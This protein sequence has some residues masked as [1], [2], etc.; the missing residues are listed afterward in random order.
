MD[1]ELDQDQSMLAKT[2]ADFARNESPVERFRKLRDDDVGYE[3]SVW[4]K[5]G[6]LGWLGVPFPDSVG[7]FGGTFTESAIVLENLATTL[8]PEPYLASVVLG[9][10]TLARA[11][12]AAQHEAYLT[13]MIEGETTL[14]L[15]YSEPH[16]RYDVEGVETKA[17]PDGGSY[18]LSGQKVWVQ[19]GHHADHL[20][21]SAQTPGGLSLFVVPRS[22]PGVTARVAKTIDGKNAAFVRFEGVRVAEDARLG[23]EGSAVAVLDRTMDY[24]AAGAVAESIGIAAEMLRLTIDYL[25]TREQ[26]GVKI[27]S[28]QALQHR[29]VDMYAETELLRSISMAAMVRADDD[30]RSARRAE[31]SAAKQQLATGGVWVAQ[32]ALQLHGGIGVTDEHD[33]GLYFKRMYALNALFGDS[34]HHVARFASDPSFVQ[35]QA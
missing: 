25:G 30:D 12:N 20:I 11:G 22:A 32:Q 28:F 27:G 21:V 24:A 4:R 14:A 3:H 23:D 5:M 1:F 35:P 13:P 17:T 9:G 7:G 8:V 2:V 34:E 31:V 10:M 15:A 6:E 29:A 33:I 18:L 26:F 19:N 16:S